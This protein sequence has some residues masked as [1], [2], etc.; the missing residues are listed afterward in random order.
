MFQ[1]NNKEYRN[2]V[3]QVLKN[4]EDIARHYEVDRIVAN[5]GIHVLG[6]LPVW[7]GDPVDKDYTLGDAYLVGESDPFDVYIYTLDYINDT[8]FW[9]DVG[10]LAIPGPQGEQGPQGERGGRGE[11][12]P[13]G[14]RGYQGLPGPQG[15][16]GET[17][18]RGEQGP[19]GIPGMNGTPGDAVRIVGVLSSE[20]DLPTDPTTVPRDTAYILTDNNTGSYIYFIT[21]IEPNLSWDHVPFENATTVIVNGQHVDIWNADTK[22]DK[23]VPSSAYDRI[24]QVINTQDRFTYRTLGTS[25]GAC[26]SGAVPIYNTAGRSETSTSSGVLTSGTPVYPYDVANKKYVDNNTVPRKTE[27]TVYSTLY[28]V[29]ADGTE[30][31]NVSYSSNAL[32]PNMIVMRRPSSTGETG[33]IRVPLE[34]KLDDSATSKQYV[35]TKVA[36]Y[37]GTTGV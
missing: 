35:D 25:T 36:K 32:D 7:T 28:G 4:K 17:G 33:S 3:E 10:P 34:T 1:F 24:A 18:E 20:N 2:L 8:R 22:V 15:V 5:Y 19:Q 6:V 14:E 29:S 37:T 11:Q 23:P 31:K 30:N 21:G 16:R 26:I 27:A 13:Q 12:G 9:L